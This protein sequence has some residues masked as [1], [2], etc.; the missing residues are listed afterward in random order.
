MR[1]SAAKGKEVGM[2]KKIMVP[3]DGSEL[4]ECVLPHVDGFVT[5]CKVETIIFV[6]VIESKH[7]P[8]VSS[9][10]SPQLIQTMKENTKVEEEQEKSSAAGYLKGVT[11]RVKQGGVEYKTDVL[12]GKTQSVHGIAWGFANHEWQSVELW[13]GHSACWQL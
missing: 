4:A 10:A 13:I 5:G 1:S 8:M 11:S 9:T 12:I 2:Y 3:L 7:Y 6:M